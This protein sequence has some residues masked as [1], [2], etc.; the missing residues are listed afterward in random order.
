MLHKAILESGVFI[1]RSGYSTIMDL[2][3]LG[4]P[5]LLIPTPGQTEQA[6]LA[7]KFLT[8]NIFFT[9][10]QNEL[11]L[12]EGIV[13]AKKRSGLQGYFFDEKAVSEAISSFLEAC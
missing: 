8:E 12:K 4:N 11:N 9:Q 1:G 3:R 6:Y 5:A 7:T 10:K 2:A 13:E